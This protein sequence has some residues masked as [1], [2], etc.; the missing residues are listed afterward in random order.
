MRR[1][2]R[3]E[4]DF[5]RYKNDIESYMDVMIFKKGFKKNS[6][7]CIRE[8]PKISYP[9]GFKKFEYYIEFLEGDK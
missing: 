7:F 6:E 5:E 3:H 4:W 1:W 2:V 9:L 8:T